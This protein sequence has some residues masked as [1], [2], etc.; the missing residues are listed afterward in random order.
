MA[1]SRKK[2]VTAGGQHP[3]QGQHGCTPT[4]SSL[5]RT[6]SNPLNRSNVIGNE[7]TPSN[8]LLPNTISNPSITSNVIDNVS[9]TPNESTNVE[10]VN[11]EAC[12]IKKRG[13]GIARGFEGEF[14]ICLSD[15]H[16]KK[17]VDKIMAKRFLTYKHRC[18][19]HYLKFQ[20]PEEAHKN[21]PEHMKAEDWAKLCGRFE[22]EEF[23]VRS[24]A[25]KN[26]RDKLEVSHTSGSKSY[27]Q[28]I[29]EM[30]L[31][32]EDL[33]KDLNENIEAN[34]DENSEQMY[35]DPIELKLYFDTHHKKDGTWT[36]P[37][38]QE[39]YEQMKALC[40]QAIDEGTKISG[41]QILEK[42]L[43]SKSGYARGLGYG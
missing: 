35:E 20:T 29:F 16:T 12:L 9:T 18:H 11:S 24:V 13:R 38:A 17:V 25:N 33:E 30:E 10:P 2:R 3:S 5:S 43:K 15:P 26:N 42:V 40:K 21:P 36:H 34:L 27:C 41:R 22:S 8:S 1:P 39:N 31:L 37:Q 19:K 14:D 28:R 4:N 32:D 23:K 6:I 7:S